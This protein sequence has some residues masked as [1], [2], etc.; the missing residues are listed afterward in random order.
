[1]Q[2]CLCF[3]WEESSHLWVCVCVCVCVKIVTTT[4][5]QAHTHARAHMHARTCTHTQTHTHTHTHRTRSLCQTAYGMKSFTPAVA[6][7]LTPDHCQHNPPHNTHTH[8]RTHTHRLDQIAW[9]EGF[10][11]SFLKSIFCLHRREGGEG[12]KRPK[13]EGKRHGWHRGRE[14]QRAISVCIPWEKS[15]P[16]SPELALICSSY[17]HSTFGGL[18][19][20]LLRQTRSTHTEPATRSHNPTRRDTVKDPRITCANTN[21]C[22]NQNNQ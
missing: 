8:A 20:C 7:L 10:L 3:K 18:V 13:K 12:R 6:G 14:G 16:I 1:M 9:W 22:D 21:T 2:L 4:T 5:T 15:S 17:H 19:W 11:R